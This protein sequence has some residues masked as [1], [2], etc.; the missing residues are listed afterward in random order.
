[1]ERPLDYLETDV[2]VGIVRQFQE[3]GTFQSEHIVWEL[4]ARHFPD[5]TPLLG[6]S[7]L[8]IMIAYELSFRV[9]EERA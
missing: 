7:L 9:Y 1:M 2:L 8:V 3:V 6:L 4:S 5:A